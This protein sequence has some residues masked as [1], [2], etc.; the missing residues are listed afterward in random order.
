M[1]LERDVEAR[2]RYD[3]LLAY[4]YRDSDGLFIDLLLV[5]EGY[6]AAFAYPPNVAHQA[7][8]DQAEPAARRR[9]SRGPSVA[10]STRRSARRRAERMTEQPVASP[11]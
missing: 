7:E 8:F 9:P 2:D 5:E 11:P 10:A 6:A 4:V 3:R 1:R